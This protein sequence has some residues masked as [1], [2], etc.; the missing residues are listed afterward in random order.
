MR[1]FC[2]LLIFSLASCSVKKQISKTESQESIK[3]EIKNT[4]TEQVNTYT[5]GN[6]TTY[7]IVVEVQDSLKPVIINLNGSTKVFSNAKRVSLVNN[8]KSLK[9]SVNTIKSHDSIVSTDSTVVKKE[10][11]KDI[12]KKNN[13]NYLIIIIFIIIILIIRKYIN[14]YNIL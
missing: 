11:K 6:D 8:I 4:Q 9:T 7:E 14:I 12:E 10:I 5:V 1:Q 3:T 2:I 13:F